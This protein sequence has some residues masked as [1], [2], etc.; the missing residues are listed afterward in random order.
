M[1]EAVDRHLALLR[2]AIDADGGVLFKM[3]GD[4]VQAIF[5]SAPG[6]IATAVAAQRALQVEQW[7]DPPGPLYVRMALNA[8]ETIPRDGDYLASPLNRPARLLVAGHGSQAEGMAASHGAL[9]FTRDRPL[10]EQALSASTGALG[11]EQLADARDAG[12][13]L[14]LEAALTGAQAIATAAM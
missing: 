6:A 4:A 9:V 5:H 8:G 11:P 7:P 10:R 14:T 13:A 12:R 2:T 3:A 1:A